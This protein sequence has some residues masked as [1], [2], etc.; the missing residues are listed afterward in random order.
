GLEGI[1]SKLADAPYHSG[2]S[3]DWM[4]TKC[5]DRQELVVAGVVPSTADSRAVG[6]LVLGFYDK[7]KLRYAGRTGTGFSQETARGLFRKLMTLKSNEIPFGNVPA[8]ERGAR[9]PIWVKPKMVVEVDIRGWTH[10]E[11]V[12]QASF[13]G[14]R[15]DKSAN[16]VVREQAIAAV[17]RPA[18]A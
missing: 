5:S 10:G 12:R 14:V 18:A 3:H 1:V 13:Q 7:G 17:N 9:K 16:E 11:R 15:E 2:R 4:K 6:A 8:E